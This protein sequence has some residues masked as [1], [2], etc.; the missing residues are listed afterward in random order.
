[1]KS[2]IRLSL[3][4]SI[5]TILVIGV[6]L[7]ICILSFRNGDAFYIGLSLLL[8]VIVCGLF[9][10]PVSISANKKE[11]IIKSSLK[12]HRIPLQ[13]IESIKLFQPTLGAI[14]LFASGGFMGYWGLFREGDVGRYMAFYGK[15]SDCFMI[16]M[17]NGDKYVLGCENPNEMVRYIKSMIQDISNKKNLDF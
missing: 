6:L 10:A 15:A 11:I 4:S 1:M 17:N 8:I 2:K 14:R 7:T 12:K 3:Y 16:K 13:N 5:I 9:Y